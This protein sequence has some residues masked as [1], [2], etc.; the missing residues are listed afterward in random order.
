[1]STEQV[2]FIKYNEWVYVSYFAGAH[3]GII[4]TFGFDAIV[5]D[6]NSDA[7]L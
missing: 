7:F 2:L 4:E 6:D 1:M 3:I 5:I